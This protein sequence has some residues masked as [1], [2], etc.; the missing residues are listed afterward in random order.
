MEIEQQKTTKV[1]A[2]T[3]EMLKLL[4]HEYGYI[5]FQCQETTTNAILEK[6]ENNTPTKDPITDLTKTVKYYLSDEK[7]KELNN[8]CKLNKT[9]KS[10]FINNAIIEYINTYHS[11]ITDYL[12]EINK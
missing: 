7:T 1:E 11:F 4:K 2:K 9:T 10:K 12:E 8:Y 5:G 3:L 6:L